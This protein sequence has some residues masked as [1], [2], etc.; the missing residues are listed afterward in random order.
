MENSKDK[1]FRTTWERIFLGAVVILVVEILVF[2]WWKA[3]SWAQ[4]HKIDNQT[5][6]LHE[7]QDALKSYESAV[8]YDR[9]LAVKDLE[10]KS[11]DMPW[12]EHIPKIL[13]MFQDLKE[14]DADDNSRIV[15]SDFYVSLEEISLKWTISALKAL[16]YNSESW[17]FKALLD[18][19]EELD[20]IKDMRIKSYEKVGS[21]NFEFIL[22]ANVVWNEQ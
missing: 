12:F 16:Y 1:K 20:F 3:Y 17:N 18:R 8:E 2:V 4:Q 7:R 19:F 13:A 11:V 14:L 15:L 10:E 5:E 22:N 9:F 21:R 6:Q